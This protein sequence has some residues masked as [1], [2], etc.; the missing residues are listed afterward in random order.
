MCGK[1]IKDS[2]IIA[3]YS[4]TQRAI[5]LILIQCRGTPITYECTK[6]GLLIISQALAMD[7]FVR[8]SLI[9]AA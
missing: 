1:I 6:F 3:A 9:D 5:S 7:D 8:A 4:Q 2:L